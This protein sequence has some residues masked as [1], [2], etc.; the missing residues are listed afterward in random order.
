M[1]RNKVLETLD[2]IEKHNDEAEENGT[3]DDRVNM[4][5]HHLCKAV[6]AALD[7]NGKEV[8]NEVDW[9]ESNIVDL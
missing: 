3:M 7:L 5:I 9:A 2:N 8:E 6:R 4:T 1:D